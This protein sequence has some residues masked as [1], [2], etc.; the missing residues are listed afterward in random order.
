VILA[1]LLLAGLGDPAPPLQVDAWLKGP[2]I[3]RFVP[4]HVYAIESWAPWCVPC[5]A[6]LPHASELQA[7]YADRNVHFIGLTGPD[8]AGNQRANVQKYLE[9][10]P[11]KTRF[12]IAWDADSDGKPA[13]DML[14]GRTTRAFYA[15]LDLEGFPATIVVDQSGRLAWTGHPTSVGPVLDAILEGRFDVAAAERERLA[16]RDAAQ[17][18]DAVQAQ[19]REGRFAEACTLARELVTGALRDD[20]DYLRLLVTTLLAKNER[21][22][23]CEKDVGLEAAT[24]AARLTERA[25]PVVLAELARAQRANGDREA[26]LGTLERA[27]ALAPPPLDA[28]LKKRFDEYSDAVVR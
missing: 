12:S 3:E 2:R 23:N 28:T 16:R 11:D 27:I 19:C 24:R 5:L 4:G 18:V 25:D 21:P 17:R 1:A 6:V 22:G 20:P 8:N 9:R 7:R 10:N 13:L 26:A 14:R 15:A